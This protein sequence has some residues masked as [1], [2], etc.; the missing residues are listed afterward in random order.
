VSRRIGPFGPFKIDAH[1]AFMHLE[2]WGEGLNAAFVQ[3]IDECKGARCVF[4]VGAH[5]GFVSLPMSQA[6]GSRG[7]VIAFEPAEA[8][9]NLLR[10]HL[11]LNSID[12]VEV[13][14]AL[15]GDT[16]GEHVA[17]FELAEPSG[18]NSL[19]VKKGSLT[20]RQSSRS[21]ISIDGF[22]RDNGLAPDVMKIDVEG[23]ELKVLRGA[24]ETLARHRPRLFLSVHPPELS[25]LGESVKEVEDLLASLHYEFFT[26]DGAQ[27]QHLSKGEFFVR[28]NQMHQ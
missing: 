5:V 12:N 20:Y 23:A 3:C 4:D 22:C 9:L 8:N 11:H 24:T 17:F 13:V 21:A 10:R 27:T 1:F 14:E 28:P 25:L 15:V 2:R 19:V 26:E 7:R 6:I 16:P 18:M